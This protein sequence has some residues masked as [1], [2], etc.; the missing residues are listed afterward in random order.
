MDSMKFFLL[1]LG[2]VICSPLGVENGVFFASLLLQ[3]L[4]ANTLSSAIVMYDGEPI[5]TGVLSQESRR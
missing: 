3:A 1:L 5:L 2:V 4:I